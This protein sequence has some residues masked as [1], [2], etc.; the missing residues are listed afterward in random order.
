MAQ[1]LKAAGWVGIGVI[2][3]ALTTVGASA[4]ARNALAPLPI[5]QLRTMAEVFSIAKQAYVDPVDEIKMLNGAVEGMVGSLDPHS[6][7]LTGKAL[8]DFREGVSGKF[9]GIGI[10]I[11]MQDGLVRIVSP[12]EGT[13]GERAG[14]RTGDLLTRIDDTNVRG[15]SMDEAIKRMRGEPNTKV[16]LM[17]FRKDE[18]RSFPVTITRAEIVQK[19]V[20]AKMVEPGYAWI[21]V[22][23][24]QEST[25]YDFIE[26]TKKLLKD[27]PKLK[28]IVL[29]LR[30][31]PGGLL[32]S[33]VGM[34]SVFLPEGLTAVTTNGQLA[35]AK[36]T[37]KIER[38]SVRDPAQPNR[39]LPN[40]HAGLP[41][42]LKGID[43][44][45]L[46]NEGSASAS[47]IVAG[48]IQDHKRGRVLGAQSFGK[49]S[50]QTEYRLSGDSSL[51]LTT[52]RYYTPSGKSIQA[53]G[54]VPDIL[55][56]EAEQ[57]NP[58]AVLRMREADYD[59]HLKTTAG[60][61]DADKS[62][63]KAREEARKAWEVEL[64]KPADQRWRAPEFG[65]DKDFQLRQALNALKGLPIVASKTQQLRKGETTAAATAPA[66]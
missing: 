59:K 60:A 29:D 40:A 54:I 8:K 37:I 53:S 35:Q 47:E 42:E 9:V 48:A 32:D 7:F 62:L 2:A 49:G 23:Q 51:K 65:T 13:P 25:A 31:N 57:G 21:R 56:D 24:F 17:V 39:R 4:I 43:V 27:D 55:V 45:V 3:G 15:L 16:N 30:S 19:S 66:K 44:V 34:L 38:E 6:T 26:H 1:K 36:G 52:S 41:E 5:D 64:Q 28:G 58:F 63:E 14:L 46:V 61:E 33:A 50:V 11:E 18:N 12:I 20:R 10:Q 22:N